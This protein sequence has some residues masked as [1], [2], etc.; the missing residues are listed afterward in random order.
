MSNLTISLVGYKRHDD[1]SPALVLPCDSLDD[2]FT[3]SWDHTQGHDR[4]E[5]EICLFDFVH[6]IDAY[7]GKYRP[8]TAAPVACSPTEQLI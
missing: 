8:P 7:G 3:Q 4:L 2:A 6:I 1:E 5:I